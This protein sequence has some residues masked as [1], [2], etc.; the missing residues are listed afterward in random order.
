[1]AAGFFAGSKWRT[2]LF[3]LLLSLENNPALKIKVSHDPS[4]IR[5]SNPMEQ[6]LEQVSYMG[7][8]GRIRMSA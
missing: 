7:L 1:M 4:C 2:A 8:E 3:P 5:P 6:S